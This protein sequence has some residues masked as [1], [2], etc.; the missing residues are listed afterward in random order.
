MRRAFALFGPAVVALAFRGAA[1]ADTIDFGQF[2]APGAILGNSLSG[3][4]TG[5][6]DF[7]ITGPGFGFKRVT[8]N[9]MGTLSP[10][11]GDRWYPSEFATGT[12]LVW[13]GNEGTGDSGPGPVTI[14][15]ATP[16]SSISTLAAEPELFGSFTAT[17]TAYDGAA[18]LGTSSYFT[19]GVLPPGAIPSFNFS[20]PAITSIVID[21]TNDGSGFALGETPEPPTWAM[22]ALGFAG[23]AFAGNRRA[24]K[25]VASAA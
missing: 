12:P 19:N 14:D 9:S 4:T 1:S 17:L 5:G 24:R 8:A 10:C 21:T 15:F 13:D 11:C 6:V 2:G 7:T 3:I 16:I 23:L 25:T 20:A 22:M 18:L